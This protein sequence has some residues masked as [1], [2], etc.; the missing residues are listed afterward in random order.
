MQRASIT[1][2]SACLVSVGA[3]GCAPAVQNAQVQGGPGG[4]VN[5]GC[6]PVFQLAN[7]V[8]V[9]C[10]VSSNHS[11]QLGNASANPIPSGTAVSFVARLAN[12]GPQCDIVAPFCG[13]ITLRQPIPPHLS[14][15]ISGQP[16][17]DS[18]APC[19]AWRNEPPVATQ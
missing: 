3:A 2:V 16:Q 10:F 8:P 11:L 5:L 9:V 6:P 19:Q 14:V 1:V 12:L 15:T 18:M 17:F 13:S 7:M 4:Q